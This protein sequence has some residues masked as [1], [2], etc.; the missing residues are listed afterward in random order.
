[1]PQQK[2]WKIS[3][4]SVFFER[5]RLAWES[6]KC[7]RIHDNNAAGEIKYLFFQWYFWN[8][9][10]DKKQ[11]ID[12]HQTMYLKSNWTSFISM[13]RLSSELFRS[14]RVWK[15]ILKQ[16]IHAHIQ[17]PLSIR[18]RVF[19]IFFYKHRCFFPLHINELK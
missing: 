12:E 10:C 17:M 7:E 13:L 15:K 5:L 19:R 16:H 4:H 11:S 18:M 8:H 6:K 2:E 14:E 1:M 9:I 3:F